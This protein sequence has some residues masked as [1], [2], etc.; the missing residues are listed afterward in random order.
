MQGFSDGKVVIEQCCWIG[1]NVTI[2]KGAEIE[3]NCVIGA[4]CVID[5][6]LLDDCV[7]KLKQKTV[8]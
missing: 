5:E 7:V 6:K 3:N 2:L 4:E 8:I 1:S